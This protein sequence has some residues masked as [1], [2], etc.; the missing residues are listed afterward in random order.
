MVQAQYRSKDKSPLILTVQKDAPAGDYDLK[1]EVSK[2]GA[3][4]R[5]R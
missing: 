1:L 3:T 2:K 5:A 4:G